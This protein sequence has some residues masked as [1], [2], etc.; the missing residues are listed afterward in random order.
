MH[1]SPTLAVV[2]LGTN[3]AQ[4]LVA[5]VEHHHS[6]HVLDHHK[7]TLRLGSALG[8]DR[9]FSKETIAVTVEAFKQMKAIAQVHDPIYRAVATHACRLAK[10]HHA[11]FMAIY[12]ATGIEV[13]LIDGLEEARLISLGIRSGISTGNKTFLGVDCGGGSTEV[14]ICKNRDIKFMTSLDLGAVLLTDKFQLQQ[15]NSSRIFAM[16]SHIIDKLEPLR[17][18]LEGLS[19]E[20]AIASSS[21]A[22]NLAVIHNSC[23]T[24]PKKLFDLNGYRLPAADL[25]KIFQDLLTI[26]SADRIGAKYDLEPKK[27]DIML[28]GAAII[29]EVSKFFNVD[30]WII[31]TSALREGVILDTL[32]RLTNSDKK[33][34]ITK[35]IRWQS[36]RV[37]GKKTAIDTE[38]ADRVMRF[39]LK[40]FDSLTDVAKLP[41]TVGQFSNRELLKAA[42]WLHEC[43][44]FLSFPR[45]HRHSHYLIVHS[46]LLGFSQH[47]RHLIGLITRYHRK[48]K[49]SKDDEDCQELTDKEIRKINIL[50]GILKL[51]TALNRTRREN[52]T[53]VNI[54][55]QA[56]NI[57]VKLS[58]DG[59]DCAK[60]NFDRAEKAAK[61][62]CQVIEKPIE[63]N[64]N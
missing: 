12:D 29:T 54:L 2:D 15:P 55:K 3:S 62:L 1:L 40:I 32:D 24:A 4:L 7:I 45:F 61:F 57:V 36:I 60:V 35:D 39:A 38:Y 25:Y 41:S 30:S 6:I 20:Y 13:E 34:E 43:G 33:N 19:F 64:L 26:G 23:Q 17:P 31:S 16:R 56:G 14:I 59:S 10:N 8:P 52:I 48:G 50:A 28:A 63:I 27:A 49:A 21:M 47:E 11:L 42:A 5:R 37:L 58:H 51:A 18:E 22:K 9:I 44:K 53:D 46:R